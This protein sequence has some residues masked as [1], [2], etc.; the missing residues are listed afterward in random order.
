MPSGVFYVC[1]LRRIAMAQKPGLGQIIVAVL[2]A[3]V[4]LL[5]TAVLNHVWPPWGHLPVCSKLHVKR[6]GG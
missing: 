4:T 1:I 6:R 2:P 5:G 3:I